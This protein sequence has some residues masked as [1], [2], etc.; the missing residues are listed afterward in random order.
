[1][2]R[3]LEVIIIM[4]VHIANLHLVYIFAKL[5]GDILDIK[6]LAVICDLTIVSLIARF[7]NKLTRREIRIFVLSNIKCGLQLRLATSL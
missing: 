1:M 2:R 5:H 4:R 3:T 6:D 7:S